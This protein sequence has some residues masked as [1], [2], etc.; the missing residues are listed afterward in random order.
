LTAFLSP[1]RV[2]RLGIT[3][4]TEVG[5]SQRKGTACTRMP[6]LGTR[7]I[8]KAPASDSIFAGYDGGQ[9]AVEIEIPKDRPE[10]SGALAGR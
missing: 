3:P 1:S 7:A 9:P 2:E 10:P 6:G 4:D 8:D 5:R